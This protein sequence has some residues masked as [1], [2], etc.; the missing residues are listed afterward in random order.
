MYYL[1]EQDVESMIIQL[2]ADNTHLEDNDTSE[3][4][5]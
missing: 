3:Q 2:K 4:G 5:T 1:N